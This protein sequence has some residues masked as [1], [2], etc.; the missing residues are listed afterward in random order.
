MKLSPE[1]IELVG[2]WVTAHGQTRADS[3]CA[4]IQ[5]LTAHHLRT[6][7]ISKQWGAWETL[8]QDPDD[9]RYWELTYPQGELHGGGP[10]TLRYI[11]KE[12]ARRKYS[13]AFAQP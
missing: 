8:F 1:E 4:R 7:A 2:E 9:G 13:D 5:W 10:P 3:T 6:V 11:S 12:G